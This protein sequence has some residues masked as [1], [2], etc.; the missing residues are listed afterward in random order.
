MIAEGSKPATVRHDQSN[1]T[2]P[3]QTS[4]EAR[5]VLSVVISMSPAELDAIAG[6]LRETSGYSDTS[7]VIRDEFLDAISS[8][9]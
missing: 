4:I 9:R 6:M 2:T 3:R 5:T 7:R 8:V 1:V